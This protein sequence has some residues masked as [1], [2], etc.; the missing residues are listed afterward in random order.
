MQ[1]NLCVFLY[2]D[3]LQIFIFYIII[4][5]TTTNKT[6]SVVTKF[7]TRSVVVFLLTC[8]RGAG[9]DVKARVVNP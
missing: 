5:K 1:C 4:L 3:I 7:A 9:G 8:H 2:S 6:T